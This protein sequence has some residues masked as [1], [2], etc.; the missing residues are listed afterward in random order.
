MMNTRRADQLTNADYIIS[1]QELTRGRW[2]V[3][4]LWQNCDSGA[5]DTMTL[6]LMRHEDGAES[7][8][9]CP[10]DTVFTVE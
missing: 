1:T 3:I 5:L 9:V 7:C 2:E 10:V 4:D 8:Y 6:V